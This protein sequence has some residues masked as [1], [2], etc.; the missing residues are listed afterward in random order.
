MKATGESSPSPETDLRTL[1]DLLPTPIFR[2]DRHGRHTFANR[3][4]ALAV[5]SEQHEM[6]GR[7]PAEA[8]IPAALAA[9]ID[10]Q[11]RGVLRTGE[12]TE[13]QLVGPTRAGNVTFLTRLVAERGPGGNIVAIAGMPRSAASRA[14]ATVPE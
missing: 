13:Y 9:I 4:A 6:R 7:T 11:V 3:A 2:L 5:G 14:A 10:H 8:G 1:L 12:P